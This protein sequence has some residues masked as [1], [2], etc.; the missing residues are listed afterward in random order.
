M[1][2]NCCKAFSGRRTLNGVATT[3]IAGTVR[4]AAAVAAVFVTDVAV[5]VTLTSAAGGEDGAVYVVG[6]P[7][8]V[9]AG[10]T[11]PHGADAQV[12]DH[13]T[14]L[15]AASLVTVAVSCAVPPAGTVLKSTVTEMS[16][17][18]TVMFAPLRAAGFAT[19]AAFKVTLRSPIGCVAGALYVTA[20]PFSDVVGETEPQESEPHATVQATP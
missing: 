11:E 13:V 6:T 16:R 5:T 18:G 4:F 2:T 8:A 10:E 14:P 15:L 19:D 9:E 7:L 12:I 1:P 20:P 3:V 17:P